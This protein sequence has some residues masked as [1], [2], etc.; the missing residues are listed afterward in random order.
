MNDSELWDIRKQLDQLSKSGEHDQAIELG[1]S[2]VDQHPDFE[3]LTSALA[4][5]YYRR[6]LG[7]LDD[8]KDLPERKRAKF[9]LDRIRALTAGDP[10]GKY[11]PL[12]NAVLRFSQALSKR[13]PREALDHLGILDPERLDNQ[14]D[15]DFEAPRVRWNLVRTRALEAAGEWADLLA[16]CDAARSDP[17]FD[18][19]SRRWLTLR[20]C[21][22][23]RHTGRAEEA[24]PILRAD[25]EKSGDWWVFERLALVHE[26]LGRPGTAIE[27]ARRAMN[28]AGKVSALNWRVVL[29]LARLLEM[30][31]PELARKHV[32]LAR[33][34]RVDNGWKAV[35][36]LENLAERLGAT[37]TEACSAKDL[38]AELAPFWRS[39][40]DSERETGRVERHINEGSGFIKPDD[41]GDSLYF[42]KPRS[43]SRPLPAI[44]ARVSYLVRMSFDRKKNRDSKVAA[45]WRE[46]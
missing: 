41:G 26:T 35:G 17:A 22:A 1:E 18:T 46:L 25:V 2:C 5:A 28:A 20:R 43:S 4:W 34:L 14:K 9:A 29:L 45:R 39:V 6:D 36:E 19:K 31:D 13:W 42:A 16:A 11:S 37:Q 32:N 24:E 15:G 8:Q 33:T 23:L 12:E 38:V 40:D 30:Q 7:G 3:P 10:Y 27:E 44:G 21:E